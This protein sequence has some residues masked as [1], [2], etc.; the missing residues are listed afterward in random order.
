MRIDT[1]F[2]ADIGKP[3]SAF[4]FDIPKGTTAITFQGEIVTPSGWPEGGIVALLGIKAGAREGKRALV[5]GLT[6]GRDRQWR[7]ESAP[8][9]QQGGPRAST[10]DTYA[11][12]LTWA[13]D[14]VALVVGG[15]HRISVPAGLTGPMTEGGVLFVG[16]DMVRP[17]KREYVAPFGFKISGEVTFRALA[18]GDPPTEGSVAYHLSELHRHL[19]ALG[20]LI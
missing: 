14:E 11:V 18:G 4:R 2:P 12:T 1:Q 3:I 9:H 15:T 13:G 8:D 16:M 17:E 10:G 6:L 20:D 19:D 5:G 7:L